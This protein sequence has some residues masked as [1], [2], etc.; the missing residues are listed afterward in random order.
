[1]VKPKS[2]FC[3]VCRV[4][5]RLAT[6]FSF[7]KQHTDKTAKLVNW[8]MRGYT[9]K[10][11]TISRIGNLSAK[12]VVRPQ[13]ATYP[14]PIDRICL[15]DSRRKRI[16]KF[17]P[18]RTKTDWPGVDGSKLRVYYI[19]SKNLYRLTNCRFEHETKE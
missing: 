16:Q 1:M 13:I 15:Q 14:F 7:S 5:V 17:P 9:L 2:S 19:N 3:R 4:Y 18:C 10:Y 11:G 12:N 6:N 8:I